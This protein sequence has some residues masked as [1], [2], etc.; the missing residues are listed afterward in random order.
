MQRVN[1]ELIP[2]L[3]LIPVIL[4]GGSGTRLWP[5]SR[6][7]FPKQYLNL[8]ENNN[9]SLLQNTYLRLK[10]IE[11][12]K[13]PIIISNEKQRFVVAEQMRE[14]NIKPNSILL[15]PKGKNTAPAVTLAALK[16]LKN[17][18][19]PLLLVLSS[20]HYIKNEEIFRKSIDNA[21][22]EANKGRLVAFGILPD[23]PET[24]YGYI[25]CYEKISNTNNLSKIKSF[26]EKPNY[27][28]AKEMIANKNFLWNSG[29]F[30]FKASIF[31]KELEK[32]EP[33]MIQ[34][35]K[36]SLEHGIEDLDFFR[37][38]EKIFKG[39]PSKP[40]DIAL[41]E[42]TKLGSVFNLNVGWNDI[43]NWQSVWET[44]K[45]DKDGNT[46]KG[47][48]I[49]EESRNCYLRSE[50]RLIVGLNIRDL[51]VVETNDAI[52][53]SDKKSSQKVK[54]IVQILNKNKFEEADTSKK[55]FRPWGSF[56]IIEKGSTWK[57]K[58]LDI[59]PNAS[60]SLQKHNHRSEHWIVV[61]GK[62]KVETDGKILFL[63]KN[64]ST[65]IPPGTTHRLS[66]PFER[67]L[68]L[69]EVQSGSYLGEDD[70]IRF[71]DNY[72]RISKQI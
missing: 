49:I 69:I 70:I 25:E 46:A 54:N 12:L 33:Q 72:G 39:C 44:S 51:I 57:V 21:I 41:M 55:D 52:L 37:I 56:T 63:Q 47:K 34:I 71:E 64:E 27:D 36:D 45:K 26:V 68:I 16:S 23:R 7:S 4:S 13:N 31:L 53:V 58:R 40:I 9:F 60:I 32:F 28:L 38:N 50:D 19:E 42:K 10:G 1:Q 48:V 61:D 65:F 59:K 30:L 35:C 5:L 2:N 20:D 18:K 8:S 62:A 6:S 11:N 3:D 66:N 14:I 43:G 29:I 17:K 24:G 22:L 15:E 67:N